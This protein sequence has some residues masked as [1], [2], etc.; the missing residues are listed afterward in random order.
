MSPP[1]ASVTEWMPCAICRS[2][3][4]I[5]ATRVSARVRLSAIS[6]RRRR[7]RPRQPEP[8]REQPLLRA[9]VQ[10]ALE[11][12]ALGLAGGHEPQR[13]FAQLLG[14][15]SLRGAQRLALERQARG[16]HRARQQLGSGAKPG[17]VLDPGDDLAA[18]LDGG[19]RAARRR[20]GRLPR[21]RRG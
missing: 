5:A 13:G 7:P 12:A 11:S 4:R 15:Q 19:A 21:C 14:L 18:A 20:G 10:V 16:P 2:W 8:E 1:S 6:R 17:A 9:V 3:S